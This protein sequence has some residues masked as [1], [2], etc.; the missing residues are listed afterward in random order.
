MLLQL[1]PR[2]IDGISLTSQGLKRFYQ[3]KRE[4]YNDLA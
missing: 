2:E 3:E 1:S 4:M